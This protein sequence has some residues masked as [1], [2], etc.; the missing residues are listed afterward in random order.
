MFL[1]R[2]SRELLDNDE[3]QVQ[4]FEITANEIIIFVK[5]I[6]LFQSCTLHMVLYLL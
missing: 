4:N 6:F 3:L 5:N 2:K 1:Q